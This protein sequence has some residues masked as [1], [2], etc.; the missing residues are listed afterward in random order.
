MS[1]SGC[2]YTHNLAPLTIPMVSR[3]I[4][5]QTRDLPRPRHNLNSDIWLQALPV[6]QHMMYPCELALSDHNSKMD[7][8]AS[9]QLF[10][11]ILFSFSFEDKNCKILR[12]FLPS[13]SLLSA[14]MSTLLRTVAS[15]AN[16]SIIFKWRR[17][18][19]L[20][21]ITLKSSAPLYRRC[22]FKSH[23]LAQTPFSSFHHKQKAKIQ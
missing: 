15:M 12:C 1:V 14:F 17:V 19:T 5:L 2:Q 3:R 7:Y 4:P 22:L 8:C 18:N 11:L 9:S 16:F 10:P 13:K 23:A 6:K 20:F 21:F